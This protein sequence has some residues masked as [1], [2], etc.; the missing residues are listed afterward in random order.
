MIKCGQCGNRISFPVYKPHSQWV[1]VARERAQRSKK[2]LKG[3]YPHCP[4]CDALLVQLEI[5]EFNQS[6]EK[7][8]TSGET[9]T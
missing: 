5:S 2:Q 4:F 3:Y 7:D 9:P 8:R 6:E 1:I